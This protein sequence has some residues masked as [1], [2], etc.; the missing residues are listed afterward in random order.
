MCGVF[1]I[2]EQDA[3]VV[4]DAD[5]VR[6]SLRLLAHRGPDTGAVHVGAGIGFAHARLTLLDPDARSNQPFWDP[7]GRYVIVYNGEI[8]NFRE[9]RADLERC[10]VAFHTTSD[11]EVVLHA[12]IRRRAT[13]ALASFDGMFAFAFYDTLEGRLLIARDRFGMKP[14]YY[15]EAGGFVAVASEVKALRPWMPFEADV[16]SISSY[17]LGFGGPTKGFTFYKGIK[18]LAPGEFVT[19]RRGQPPSSDTYRSVSDFLDDGEMQGLRQQSPR[20]LVDRMEQLLFESVKRQLFA[21]APVGAFCSGGV[22]SSLIVAMA[23]KLHNNLAIFHANIVGPWSEYQAARQ[24]SAHL[25]LDL[26]AVEVNAGDFLRELPAAM[27]H[28]EHPYTYMPNAV[29]FMMVARLV[30]QHGVKA[31]MSGE[32]SD[33]LF[34][35]YPWLGRQRIV[36]AYHAL[37]VRLR[38]QVHRIPTLG[39]IIWPDAGNGRE[40]V[41]TLLNRGEQAVDERRIDAAVAAS[42]TGRLNPDQL[43][44]LEYLNYHLRT[45]LHR[46][47]SLGME[48]GI[49]ARFPFLD[50]AVARTALNLPARYKLRFAP[51]VLEKAHPFVRDKWIIREVAGRWIPRTLSHRTKIGFWTT[52]FERMDVRQ[53]YFE[54]SRIRDLFEIAAAEMG[55]VFRSADQDLRMRLL[56][57]DVWMQV[58][59]EQR[60]VAEAADKL[61]AHVSIRPE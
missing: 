17:L 53:S 30:R 57:L 41:Q 19:W 32:G 33:E 51:L 40:V 14:M 36:D 24:L 9:L 4:P 20:Q 26:H 7:T 38:T 54:R 56:H 6:A 39:R 35:G 60:G 2:F 16:F 49:E 37:G 46:N 10:G 43:T 34:L 11:T 48:A 50:H 44:S 25:K 12:L 42:S 29:P 15:C 3:G 55:H 47:D 52:I 45:L 31:V 5:A 61:A 22:D 8:Y 13:D 28:Y 21:D 18:A 23:A 59:L 27:R 58:C 1:G